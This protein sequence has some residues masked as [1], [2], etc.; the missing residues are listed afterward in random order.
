VAWLEQWL[1]QSVVRLL[2]ESVVRPAGELL[3]APVAERVAAVFA[4][5]PE[6][7]LVLVLPLLQERRSHQGRP[8]L[9]HRPVNHWSAVA[10]VALRREFALLLG[11]VCPNWT[12]GFRR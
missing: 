11:F 3:A 10:T 8:T 5:L 12:H 7:E 9:S 2:E 6:L 1:E 4:P